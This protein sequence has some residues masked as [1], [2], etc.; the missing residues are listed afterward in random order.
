[1]QKLSGITI[2]IELEFSTCKRLL[3]ALLFLLTACE[4]KLELAGVEETLAGSSIRTDQYLSM[5]VIG[6]RTVLLGD[7]G[8]VLFSDDNGKVWTRLS[9]EQ[10]P[11]FISSSI[12]PDGSIVALS[13]DKRV[14]RSTDK[15]ET[16]LPQQ[17]DSQEDLQTIYCSV[18]SSLWITASF[19][20]L[21]KSSDN[22]IT[23]TEQSLNE[24]AMLTHV[25]FFDVN[26]G[27]T[28]GE[29][30]SFFTTKDGGATWQ[31]G[32]SIGEEFFPLD[33]WFRN[34]ESG[35]AVGLNS[36][37][38]ATNDGGVSW[39][40]QTSESVAVPIYALVGNESEVYALGD[41]GAALQLQNERWIQLDAPKTPVHF[42]TGRI[43]DDGN[44]LVAGGWGTI[45][46]IPTN[47]P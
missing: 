5:E 46:V 34:R 30:S 4:A 21:L 9:L 47:Q 19:S 11:N 23:W 6:E 44:L 12:C 1:M 25:Q 41:N 39:Q 20:T 24:D 22:G 31:A 8:V 36:V 15:A 26:D 16:W 37:I 2:A 14:W 29:F 27:V 38:F 43:L 42:A 3:V 13:F 33:V 32:G 7:N 45:A 28:A 10:S 35:W 40:R 17:V 18:D